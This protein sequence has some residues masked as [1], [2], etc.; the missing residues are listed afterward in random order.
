[1]KKILLSLSAIAFAACSL[2]AQTRYVDEVYS[3]EEIDIAMNIPYSENY[4]VLYGDIDPTTPGTQFKLDTLLADF[5]YPPYDATVGERPI[6]FVLHSGSFLP[7]YINNSA[8]GYKD[9]SAPP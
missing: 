9:D 3:D 5:Y 1:M 2:N 4:T 6:V 8:V 7:R